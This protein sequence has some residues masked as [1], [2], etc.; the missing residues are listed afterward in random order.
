MRKLGKIG[1]FTNKLLFIKYK[2]AFCLPLNPIPYF[3]TTQN[4]ISDN[5]YIVF[6]PVCFSELLNKWITKVSKNV[7][8]NQRPYLNVA[9]TCYHKFCFVWASGTPSSKAA[10]ENAKRFKLLH[11]KRHG[12]THPPRNV[13]MT[14]RVAIWVWILPD[15]LSKGRFPLNEIHIGLYIHISYQGKFSEI[16][17]N[18]YMTKDE[19]NC[20]PC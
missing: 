7:F 6:T 4:R 2:T 19:K 18:F 3:L 15:C 14:F 17:T 11:T 9:N 13:I 12:K 20:L 1:F 8:L 16:L 5:I 10:Y